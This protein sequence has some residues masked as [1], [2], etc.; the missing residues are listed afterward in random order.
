MSS[1]KYSMSFTAGSLLLKKSVIA[2]ELYSDLRDWKLVRDK[3]IQDNLLQSRSL[4]SLKRHTREIISRLRTLSEKELEWLSYQPENKLA[5]MLWVAVCRRYTFIGEFASEVIRER[6]LNLQP[7]IS[8]EDYNVFFNQKAQWHEELDRITESTQKEQ[9]RIVF[10]MLRQVNLIDKQNNIIPILLPAD[11]VELLRKR[12]DRND[13]H[14]FP[15]FDSDLPSSWA[16]DFPHYP[17]LKNSIICSRS[18]P[19]S[20]FLQSKA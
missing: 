3:I 17:F 14:L 4:N 16:L 1:A 8:T 7:Q 9:R 2:L 13:L 12:T 18:P 15:V 11:F 19:A 20:A 6:Y 10:Q 5:L